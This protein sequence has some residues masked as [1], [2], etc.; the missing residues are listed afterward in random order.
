MSNIDLILELL[1]DI[2]PDGYCDDC[3]S[4]ELHIHPRQ[5]VNQICRKLEING[6]LNRQKS[7][8]SSCKKNK[9]INIRHLDGQ[10]IPVPKENAV[11]VAVSSIK[12]NKVEEEIDIEHARNEIVRICHQIWSKNKP[13]IPSPRGI[14]NLINQLKQEG[15]IPSHQVNMMLTL[16]GIRN[17]YVYEDF[18]LGYQE[19]VI[20]RYSYSIVQEWWNSV[21]K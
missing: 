13:N 5:Q 14:S 10:I 18:Q 2:S 19:K 20:A 1:D 8:C 3:I 17:V 4:G 15:L 7:D 9:T 11:S 16:C 6:K 21:Q 12:A